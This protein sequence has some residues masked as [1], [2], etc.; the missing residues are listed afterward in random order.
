MGEDLAK[1]VLTPHL[2]GM[3]GQLQDWSRGLPSS[4]GAFKSFRK[5][6]R[7]RQRKISVLDEVRN[8][9]EKRQC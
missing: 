7:R 6:L 8:R 9:R 2:E 1:R 3:I 5:S 4:D